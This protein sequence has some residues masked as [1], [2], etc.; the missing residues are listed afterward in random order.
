M[1][2]RF[3]T[4][5]NDEENPA[6]INISSI[7]ICLMT[8]EKRFWT[9]KYSMESNIVEEELF[10]SKEECLNKFERVRKLLKARKIENLSNVKPVHE[11]DN[12]FVNQNN[13]KKMVLYKSNNDDDEYKDKWFIRYVYKINLLTKDQVFT[14]IFDTEEQAREVFNQLKMELCFKGLGVIENENQ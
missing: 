7:N 8:K 9:I 14:E 10:D 12:F 4:F 2:N 13:A 3:I 11:G 6:I 1:D 5:I